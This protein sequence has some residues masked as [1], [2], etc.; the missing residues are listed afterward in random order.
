MPRVFFAIP[1]SLAVSRTFVSCREAI[2]AEDPAW[3]GEKWVDPANLHITIRFL[4]TVQGPEVQRCITEAT[5]AL[6][7]LEPY[8]LRLDLIHAIPQRGSASLLWVAPSTG[9]EETTALAD[10]IAH[11]T[12]FVDPHPDGK[13]FRPHVTLCRARSPRRISA[14][15]LEQVE[16]LLHS[17]DDRVISMSVPGVTLLTSTLTPRGPVYEEVATV[18]LGS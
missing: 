9:A 16:R 4:G 2:I 13:R 1:L 6:A 11:A 7:T 10:A 14:D 12:S 8:R 17:A 18:P 15:A 3:V 5:R